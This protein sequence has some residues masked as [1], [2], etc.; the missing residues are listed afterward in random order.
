MPAPGLETYWADETAYH[1]ELVSDGGRPAY[2]I[3]LLKDVSTSPAKYSAIVSIWHTDKGDWRVFRT[4]LKKWKNF[5]M[6]QKD[7]RDINED[8]AEWEDHVQFEKRFLERRGVRMLSHVAETIGRAHWQGK[9]DTRRD[10]VREPNAVDLPTYVEA[11]KT[12]LAYHGFAVPPHF[13]LDQDPKRQDIVTTWIEYLCF[14]YWWVDS[15]RSYVRNH[16]PKYDHAW[17]KLKQSGVLR[18]PETEDYVWAFVNA[19]ARELE[20]DAVQRQAE[21][22]AAALKGLKGG[23]AGS[24]E[25][26]VGHH[27]KA[28][29]VLASPVEGDQASSPVKGDEA[30]SPVK[31]DEAGSPVKD[32]EAESPAKGDKPGS[33]VQGDEPGSPAKSGEPGSSVKGDEPGSPVKSDRPGSPVERDEPGSAD[34][35]AEPDL[36]VGGNGSTSQQKDRETSS[37]QKDD[38]PGSPARSD[39]FGSLFGSD[40]S[41]PQQMDDENNSQLKDD[42][43]VTMPDPNAEFRAF[44]IQAAQTKYDEAMKCLQFMGQR[45]RLFRDLEDNGRDYWDGK[46][47]LDQV[48]RVAA[49]VLEQVQLLV[50]EANAQASVSK[51]EKRKSAQSL[52]AEAE[53]EAS[54]SKAEKRKSVQLLAAEA[55]PQASVSKAEKRKSVQFLVAEADAQVSVPRAEK[56]KRAPT[57]FPGSKKRKVEKQQDRQEGSGRPLRRSA[58]IAAMQARKA[59]SRR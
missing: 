29:G 36:P 16:Q 3:N 35:N 52:P 53:A 13:Q 21:L 44:M 45:Q 47:I 34:K 15:Q 12:R 38:E 8:D 25:L 19:Q 46:E 33:P 50:A 24:V 58:R 6:W 22:A 23:E 7:N 55:D 26:E 40:E 11:V 43:A 10:S 32:N 4:Q 1:D 17:T 59:A 31:N 48:E 20:Y 49:W 5:R 37:Q 57:R 30:R 27:T 54:V 28:A 51:A 2:P 14:S 9:R 41:G 56:R 18:P 42:E 39:E